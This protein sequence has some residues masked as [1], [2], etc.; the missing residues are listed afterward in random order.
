M[1]VEIE[2]K[3]K[4]ESLEAVRERL[5]AVEAVFVR[6]VTERNL[7]YDSADGRLR[8]GD[9]VLRIRSLEVH[10]GAALPATLTYKGP[11]L[12]GRVKHRTEIEL[13]VPDAESATGLLEALGYVRLCLLEKRRETWQLESC[14]VELDELP[15]LG[16]FVEIEGP[17]E[18]S[19]TRVQQRLGLSDRPHIPQGYIALLHQHC[20]SHG[21]PF[22]EIT[23]ARAAEHTGTRSEP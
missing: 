12:P 20:Q 13:A 14:H 10:R 8:R 5:Q 11:R 17:D 21:L 1:P 2:A 18:A 7:Q 9:S 22:A 23:F 16:S 15:Y 4:V 6:D 19:I 3:L